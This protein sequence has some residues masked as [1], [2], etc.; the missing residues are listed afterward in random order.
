MGYNTGSWHCL[1]LKQSPRLTDIGI[2]VELAQVKWIGDLTGQAIRIL[3]ELS[4]LVHNRKRVLLLTHGLA[5]KVACG[6]FR[7]GKLAERMVVS[8]YRERMVKEVRRKFGRTS[9]QKQDIHAR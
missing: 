3:M 1:S 5:S 8:D 9:I 7:Q 2:A 6:I 4:R